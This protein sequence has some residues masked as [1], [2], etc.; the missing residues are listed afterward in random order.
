MSRTKVVD[1]PSFIK[2]ALEV[3]T[4]G[5]YSYPN[6]VF[7]NARERIEIE[8]SIHGTFMQDSYNHINK[9]R[10]CRA[11]S[12]VELSNARKGEFT[13]RKTQED[14]IKDA[15]AIHGDTYD[16]SKVDYQTKYTDVTIIC[17]KHGEFN[18]RPNN[19]L[20][21]KS[22]CKACGIE[23]AHAKTRLTQ[24]ELLARF[25][26]V[27]GDTFEYKKVE[28]YKTK[29][30]SVT[31]ICKTHGE[32]TQRCSD[33][34]L[35]GYGCPKCSMNGTSK[36]EMEVAEFVQ[37]L[38]LEIIQSDRSLIKPLEL[39]IVIPSLKI[40]IEY[41]GLY[42][43][44]TAMKESTRYHLDKTRMAE[45]AGY[46]LI[47][48]YED[49]WVKNKDLVKAKLISIF[50]M[51]DRSKFLNARSLK[52]VTIEVAEA[53]AFL[54]QYH[55]QGGNKGSSFCYSLQDTLG[56]IQAVMTFGRTRDIVTGEEGVYELTKFAA[57]TNIRGGFSKLLKTFIRE[58][59]S[60][61]RVISYSDKRWS[62]GGMYERNGFTKTSTS[63]PSYD[64]CNSSGDR[65]S[66]QR[67]RKEKLKLMLGDLYSE[68][69]TEW[70]MCEKELGLWRIYNCG[71]DRWEFKV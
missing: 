6:S 31:I 15:I 41:D 62:K 42:F 18:V 69:R 60:V 38:G 63:N 1:T 19:H 47:H 20:Q 4:H 7:K 24:E 26:N 59:P 2:A 12:F 34:Y 16:Y 21:S 44:S 71:M 25:R 55:I 3:H 37:S 68:D 45:E 13:T 9:S 66:K 61:K 36:Q 70:D 5:R 33:H 35:K 23:Q 14:F 64:Y 39:D 58:S 49:E 17:K 30:D 53:N 29:H 27:Y 51:A 32:F 8:C 40:A 11:C 28:N 50:G 46:R 22:G 43:H 52:V 65:F 10:G 54:S 56:N 57:M 48:L 67:F